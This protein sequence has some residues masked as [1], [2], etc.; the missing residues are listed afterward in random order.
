[1]SFYFSLW[2]GCKLKMIT[3]QD[4]TTF[5]LNAIINSKSM[6]HD[7]TKSKEEIFFRQLIFIYKGEKPVN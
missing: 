6:F 5:F 2:G 1:M 7:V 3:T 4:E